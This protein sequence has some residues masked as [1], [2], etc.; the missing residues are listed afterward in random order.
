[1]NPTTIYK[2]RIQDLKNNEYITRCLTWPTLADIRTILD[3]EIA[4]LKQR[5]HTEQANYVDHIWQRVEKLKRLVDMLLV[6]KDHPE[7]TVIPYTVPV[8]LAGRMIGS[9]DAISEVAFQARLPPTN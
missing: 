7:P 9:I 1:M 5:A 3:Y 8:L 2:I 6:V 4:E